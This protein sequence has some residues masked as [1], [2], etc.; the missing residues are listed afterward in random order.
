ML[1]GRKLPLFSRRALLALTTSLAGAR[2]KGAGGQSGRALSGGGGGGG[3]PWEAFGRCPREGKRSPLLPGNAN[4][5]KYSTATEEKQ[6]A[7]N[8]LQGANEGIAEIVMNRLK[9]R[10]SLGKV[11]VSQLF[12]AVEG[13]RNDNAVR[14]VVFKSEVKGVFCAGADL[15]ERAQ[16]S[17][18]EVGHF[19]HKLRTLM[20][21]IA[22]LPM[23]TVAAVDGYALGGG[24]ELAM[25][26]DI[27]VA[28][29]SAKMGLIE[30]TRGLLPGAGG[31][32]RLPRIVGVGLAKELIFTGRQ[33][34]GEQAQVIGL[35]SHAVPQN[36]SGDA[37]YQ[38]ALALAKEVL[39]QAPVAVKMAKE[40]INRGI[41]VD[42]ATGMAIEEMCYAR[43]IPT[44][45]RLEG[46]AAFMEK[47]LPQ[48]KGE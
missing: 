42:I 20:N 5:R 24:L 10:N 1:P 23:P 36:A 46:M 34:D 17:N 22:V 7:I 40:A 30:T 37:A 6:I 32:Q 14:V 8:R 26:C 28:A 21:E 41:E 29:S 38:K 47:R 13:L 4:L 11:F 35:V 33:L 27:R 25:A 31:S 3:F 48:F 19:V 15:K 16:M 43:V 9:A 2:A 39:P 12:E 18:A 44:K 45:D